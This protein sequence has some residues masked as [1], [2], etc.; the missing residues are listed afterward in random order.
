MARPHPRDR[1]DSIDGHRAMG[2][3]EPGDFPDVRSRPATFAAVS[4]ATDRAD[5]KI[6][7]TGYAGARQAARE[8]GNDYVSGGLALAQ[9]TGAAYLVTLAEHQHRCARRLADLL[10]DGAQVWP[11]HRLRQLLLRHPVRRTRMRRRFADGGP[12]RQPPRVRPFK[13][14]LIA[15]SRPL[16]RA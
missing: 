10:P 2:V 7:A 12:R 15:R 6:I 14:R 16:R 3:S 11:T 9:L 5:F 8:R 13:R 1:V 4:S